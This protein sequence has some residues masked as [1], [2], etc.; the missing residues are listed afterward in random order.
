MSLKNFLEQNSPNIQNLDN[1]SKFCR[2]SCWGPS[3]HPLGHLSWATIIHIN[4]IRC[5]SPPPVTTVTIR[6]RWLVTISSTVDA[7]HLLRSCCP[8]TFAYPFSPQPYAL[9]LEVFNR[10]Q[11]GLVIASRQPRWG[12]G[13][14]LPGIT[15]DH[16]RAP[17]REL[18]LVI[19]RQGKCQLSFSCTIKLIMN[20]HRN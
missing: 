2:P 19:C 4:V 17:A 13:S 16:D 3:I 11:D 9:E 7:V 12:G 1:E 10:V 14:L 18:F 8:S 6:R 20:Q 15:V 5:C